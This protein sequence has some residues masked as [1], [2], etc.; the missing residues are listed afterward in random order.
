MPQKVLDFDDKE[1]RLNY[2]TL[3]PLKNMSK[4]E[5]IPDDNPD[6]DEK[7]LDN[8]SPFADV[9]NSAAFARKIRKNGWRF[10]SPLS[11]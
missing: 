2:K 7:E 3:D 10:S 5:Y 8:V 1:P 11:T 4:I 9:E 6:V